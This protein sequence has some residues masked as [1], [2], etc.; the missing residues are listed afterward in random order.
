MNEEY[1]EYK[2]KVCHFTPRF[3]NV[4]NIIYRLTP[5]FGRTEGSGRRTNNVWLRGFDPTTITSR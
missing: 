4:V 5:K 1:F 2:G 3:L